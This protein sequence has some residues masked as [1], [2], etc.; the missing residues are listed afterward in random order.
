MFLKMT[1]GTLLYTE[2]KATDSLFKNNQY[3]KY[4]KKKKKRKVP[5][6]N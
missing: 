4:Q 2:K 3:I 6:L 1:M 5:K